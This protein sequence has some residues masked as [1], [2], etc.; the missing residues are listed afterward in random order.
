[1]KLGY[2]ATRTSC[3]AADA[4]ASWDAAGEIPLSRIF[5]SPFG[6][7]FL[8]FVPIGQSSVLERMVGHELAYA[9]KEVVMRA[10][11]RP[12]L[13]ETVREVE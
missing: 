7:H 11:D 12:E 1:M 5:E 9:E 4:A 6:A 8:K 10:L 2:S 13:A 3:A